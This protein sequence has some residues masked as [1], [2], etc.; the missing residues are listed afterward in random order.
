MLVGEA[1]VV[2]AEAVQDGGVDGNLG[3]SGGGVV[4]KFVGLPV[5]HAGF[6]PAAR[7]PHG[8]TTGVMIAAIG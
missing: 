1:L 5:G 7:H 8:E 4:A 6:D 2:D 3:A